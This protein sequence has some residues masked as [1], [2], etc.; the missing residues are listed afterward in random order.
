MKQ[1]DKDVSGLKATVTIVTGAGGGIGRATAVRLAAEGSRV[2]I[3]DLNAGGL[4]ETAGIIREAGGEVID[5]AGDIVSAET[6]DELTTKV[7]DAY[8]RIDGLV[9]NAGVVNVKPI[10]QNT[11]E[12]FDRMLHINTWS[13]L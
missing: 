3:T 11:V 5:L 6:I 12:D 2:G 7:V 10:L 1:G 8:G 4:K 13:Y 9:N